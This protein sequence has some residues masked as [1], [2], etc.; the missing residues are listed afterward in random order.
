MTCR[1]F[2]STLVF[3]GLLVGCSEQDMPT[4]AKKPIFGEAGSSGCYTVKFTDH[5]VF[6]GFSPEGPFYEGTL[7][8]DLVGTSYMVF[9]PS[10]FRFSGVTQKAEAVFTYT[11][12]GGIISELVGQ[13]FTVAEENINLYVPA[14]QDLIINVG[15]ARAIDGVEKANL[16]WRGYTPKGSGTSFLE[17]DGVICP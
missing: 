7:A 11:I 4:E 3:F 5:A 6:G 9:Q 1:T 10:S 14:D 16:T 15:K 12:T 17:Y 2:F 13:S 8:G